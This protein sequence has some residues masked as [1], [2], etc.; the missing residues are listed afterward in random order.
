[1]RSSLMMAL[2]RGL[3]HAGPSRIPSGAGPATP[4]RDYRTGRYRYCVRITQCQHFPGYIFPRSA[5]A[6]TVKGLVLES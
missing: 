4:A 5:T 3:G 6:A 2:G 1:M